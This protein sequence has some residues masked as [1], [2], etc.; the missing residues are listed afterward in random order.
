MQ[1]GATSSELGV[2]GEE[3]VMRN[4]MLILLLIVATGIAQAGQSLIDA[5]APDF[6]L[7]DQHGK[8]FSLKQLEGKPMLL[9]ACD[10]EGKKQKGDWIKVVTEKYGQQ[11]IVLGVADVRKV[12]FFLKGK[13]TRDFQK[14]PASILLDWDG[15]IF[16]SYGL[17]KDVANIIVIDK[18]GYV[19][20]LYSGSAERT[21][22]EQLFRELDQSLK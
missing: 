1:F 10:N 9:I 21:A 8:A 14:D 12:P 16:T 15:T 7:L 17:V 18:K 11:L 6:S 13:Y 4:S 22:V 19:R 5:K 20:Y 2:R 3:V